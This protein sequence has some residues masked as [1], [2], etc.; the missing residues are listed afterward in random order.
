MFFYEDGKTLLSLNILVKYCYKQLKCARG[1]D[2]IRILN[3]PTT[4]IVS[5]KPPVVP[6]GLADRTY[7]W[8]A[9]AGGPIKHL[10]LLNSNI[11]TAS[12]LTL[13]SNICQPAMKF[14]T[15]NW[16]G[17]LKTVNKTQ[18]YGG[19]ISILFQAHYQTKQ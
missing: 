1:Y 8:L 9:I 15:W 17:I 11:N 18:N 7:T 5:D 14:H 3:S 16:N 2:V 12:L 13:T 6:S 10:D 19:D 4:F